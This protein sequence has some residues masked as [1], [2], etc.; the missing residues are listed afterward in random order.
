MSPERGEHGAPK[1]FSLSQSNIFDSDAKLARLWVKNH[2][3]LEQ[4]RFGLAC[5]QQSGR[6][7][8]IS[9]SFFE[10]ALSLIGRA[11]VTNATN[12]KSLDWVSFELCAANGGSENCRTGGALL[13]I[14]AK[15][16]LPFSVPN[17]RASLF[18]RFLLYKP[19][20]RVHYGPDLGQKFG[21]TLPLPLC[22]KVDAARQA[23]R[24]QVRQK[25]LSADFCSQF[26]TPKRQLLKLVSAIM[27]TFLLD[28]VAF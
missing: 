21:A 6:V 7:S 2:Y 4:K 15:K 27:T 24:R 20:S 22:T 5:C 25:K 18:L 17:D 3:W 12:A 1:Y 19:R 23:G 14:F 13:H 16:V 26:C 9:C 28:P 10:R 11:S 8:L